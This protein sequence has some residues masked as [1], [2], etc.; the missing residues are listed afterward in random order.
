MSKLDK[1]LGHLTIDGLDAW[2]DL[3]FVVRPGSME[4]WLL[5]PDTKEP[6]SHDWKDENGI[7]VDLTHSYVKEKKVSLKVCLISFS[8]LEFQSKYDALCSLLKSPGIRTLYYRELNKTFQA[9][10]TRSSEMKRIKG[11]KNTDM[12]L[13]EMTLFFTMPVPT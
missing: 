3:G 9:Y 6:F 13:F 12:I 5:P 10:Y 11:V 1:M 8:A 4:S 2:G 7:E